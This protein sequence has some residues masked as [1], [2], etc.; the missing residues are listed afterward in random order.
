MY[1]R[2]PFDRS[3]TV[4][5]LGLKLLTRIKAED[6]QRVIRAFLGRSQP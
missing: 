1:E 3:E 6:E 5:D 4:R 2:L